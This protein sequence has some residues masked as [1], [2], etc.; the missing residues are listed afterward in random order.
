MPTPIQFS[1]RYGLDITIKKFGE[2]SGSE[3]TIDFANVCDV[4]ISGDRVWAT[5][6]QDH[7]NKIAFNNPL[8]GTFKISTQIM[9]TQLLALM[10]GDDNPASVTDTSTVVFKNDAA[11]ACPEYF[12]ITATT[13]WQDANGVTYSETMTFHKV[14]PKR[15]LNISYSGTGDPTSVD[16]E[17]DVLA[18]ASGNV[19]TITKATGGATT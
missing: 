5:G 4:N 12:E 19:V 10:S 14:C 8:E 2:T 17:F 11:S 13:V 3:L 9:T 15:A 16:V 18:D 1:N 6:G 7:S